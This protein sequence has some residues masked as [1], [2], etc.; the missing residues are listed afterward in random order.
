MQI[1]I[2]NSVGSVELSDKVENIEMTYH[3]DY[4]IIVIIYV[5]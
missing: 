4:I 1:I 3:P 2:Y 5:T